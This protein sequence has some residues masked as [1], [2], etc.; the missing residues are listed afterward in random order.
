MKHIFTFLIIFS[1][2]SL[3]A[4]RYTS[5]VFSDAEITVTS[6]VPYGSNATV[7]NMLFLG[8]TEFVEQTLVMDV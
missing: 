1:T 3:T 2:L 5:E 7:F 8:A 6:N 4:Q